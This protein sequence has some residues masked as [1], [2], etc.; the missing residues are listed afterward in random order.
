MAQKK[1]FRSAAKARTFQSPTA[2][3]QASRGEI[4]RDTQ[5]RVEAIELQARQLQAQAKTH[6]QGI[7]NAAQFEESVLKEK[8]RLESKVRSH[9]LEA[10]R[11][12][13]DTHVQ[14]LQDKA[15]WMAKDAQRLADLAPKQARAAETLFK[16]VHQLGDTMIG[17]NQWE[18]L[19]GTIDPKTG[20]SMLQTLI[21]GK[22]DANYSIV[23]DATND[24]FKVTTEGDPD[25]ANALIDR[26]INL[27]SHWAQKKFASW[28]KDNKEALRR[29]V[30][31][32]FEARDADGLNPKFVY[33]ESNAIQAQ[34]FGALGLLRKL[35]I[36]NNS[37]V[38]Y[39]IFQQFRSMGAL[40]KEGF[41]Q[42][43]MVDESTKR[44]MKLRDA[45][46]ADGSQGK[47]SNLSFN[48]YV[49]SWK[50]S[51]W[52]ENG[53]FI[54]P[55]KGGGKYASMGDVYKDVLID[56]YSHGITKGTINAHNIDKY[57]DGLRIIGSESKL[58]KYKFPI[59][60]AEAR[61]EGMKLLE[62]QIQKNERQKKLNGEAHYQQ[63]QV[64]GGLRDQITE[65]G[66]TTLTEIGKV[67]DYIIENGIGSKE[68]AKIMRLFGYVGSDYDAN[69]TL[70]NVIRA[71]NDGDYD[72][73]V[74]IWNG[75]QGNLTKQQKEFLQ[76]QVYFYKKLHEAVHGG[77]RQIRLDLRDKLAN[78][79]KETDRFQKGWRLT[80][81]G[82]KVVDRQLA[83]YLKAFRAQL[84][85]E[86]EAG[87][88]AA[89][90]AGVRD[91]AKEISTRI[92]ADIEKAFDE[93][94]QLVEKDGRWERKDG[95]APKEF[96]YY[97][98][99]WGPTAFPL[100]G[101]K[102][103]R[104]ASLIKARMVSKDSYES[105]IYS[106]NNTIPWKTEHIDQI[107]STAGVVEPDA[108]IDYALNNEHFED[109]KLI[110]T[111]VNYLKSLKKEDVSTK[112]IQEPQLPN[113]NYFWEKMACQ[114]G[115]KPTK[116]VLKRKLLEIRNVPKEFWPPLDVDDQQAIQTDETCAVKS[117]RNITNGAYTI[118]QA[119]IAQGLSPMGK[120]A[121]NTRTLGLNRTE[122]FM[123]I[124]PNATLAQR[125]FNTDIE[126]DLNDMAI[127]LYTQR[128]LS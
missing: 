105:I 109:P 71:G 17:I 120:M 31:A 113:L 29:D 2:R 116:I 93:K 107:I 112:G 86:H 24:T 121:H 43:R 19:E 88:T 32:N 37:K 127:R 52:M 21:D 54:D 126:S 106:T 49:L 12:R 76:K 45:F 85:Y 115:K 41:W 5:R 46:L 35:G 99:T 74:A 9:S 103:A 89:E 114:G 61:E 90:Q 3:L 110:D 73:V 98:P 48:N 42:G 6:I 13:R 97:K 63:I 57:D 82:N 69:G 92:F 10:L 72:E 123:Q 53:K 60:H 95:S 70:A 111:Y 118:V 59:K 83:I 81:E 39:E 67:N 58:W 18:Q 94:Q 64:K 56:L 77:A 55:S 8:N 4:E 79:L 80:N 108:I 84:T 100:I 27:S 33:G 66:I 11:V 87:F 50:N 15:T 102:A 22:A 104:D 101:D 25:A 117:A 34:E 122:A 75:S 38:G 20:K 26:T 68:A 16:G 30:V 51:Y 62:K 119:I 65:D 1:K 47:D 78:N 124:N 23:W 128:L 40:D 91:N 96:D 7:V 36:S 14:A 44:R 28:V 125:M